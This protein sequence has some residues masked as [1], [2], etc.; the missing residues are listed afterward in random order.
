MTGKLCPKMLNFVL[1]NLA[2]LFQ[3][4]LFQKKNAAPSNKKA[5]SAKKLTAF[6]TG[7]IVFTGKRKKHLHVMK[8]MCQLFSS[9]AHFQQNIH[10]TFPATAPE[11]KVGLFP[12][13][14]II[15]VTTI[16]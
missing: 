2:L 6:C 5:L 9:A 4:C 13:R 11:I 12:P 3:D 16:Y 15:L 7:N 8:T 10:C 1:G 14:T